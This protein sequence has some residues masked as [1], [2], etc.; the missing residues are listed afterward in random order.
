MDDGL[1]GR[2]GGFFD[3]RALDAVTDTEEYRRIP[4]DILPYPEDEAAGDPGACFACSYVPNAS[5]TKQGQGGIRNVYLEM[6]GIIH[7]SYGNTT[8]TNLVNMV[9]EFYMREIKMF[10]NYPAWSKRCIWEHIHLHMQ[11][12]HVQTSETIQ[13][14]T[15]AMVLIQNEGL[16]VKH[17][18]RLAIDNKSMK[19]YLEMG[20][21]REIL[22]S[23]RLKRRA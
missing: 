19:L 20:K 10:F 3:E 17:G 11:N 9:H 15:T 13:T 2:A 18:E 4:G 12:D 16:C 21:T 6:M 7:K 22:I 14:I 8:N 23:S 1:Q 5:D